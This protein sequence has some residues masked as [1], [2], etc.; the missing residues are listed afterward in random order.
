MANHRATLARAALAGLIAISLFAS[1][2]RPAEAKSP[3]GATNA[4]AAREDATRGVPFAKLSPRLAPQIQRVVGHP[5]IYR[6]LPIQVIDC[7]P[8]MY[9][10]L[11][12]NPEV[13]VN[14]WQVM[15]ITKVQIT[16]TSPTSYEASDGAG[17]VGKLEIAY[18][19][20]DTQVVYCEG[21][22]EG[23]MFSKPLRAQCVLLFKAGYVQDTNR[24]Y[25][26]SAR[27]DAFIRL[28]NVGL[29]ILAKTFQPMVNNSA[30][31]NFVE[32]AAFI[33]TV[34]RTSERKPTGMAKLGNRLQNISP[35]VRENFIDLT[36]QVATRTR[37]NQAELAQFDRRGAQ[38]M[39]G[40]NSRGQ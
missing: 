23:P 7:D 4:R 38:Q 9:H 20:Q 5:S 22:Y 33:S 10:F 18:S 21:M 6:R 37:Q 16:R 34:S 2:S 3:S 27:C 29:E 13:I 14:I 25:F 17:A 12:N 32:T 30:D 19:D 39:R 26:I 35:E 28:E 36:Q 15:G 1:H 24:R 8:K 31:A 40:Q 11:L